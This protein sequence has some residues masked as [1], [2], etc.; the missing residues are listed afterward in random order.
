[1]S[2]RE[3]KTLVHNKKKS[4]FRGKTGGYGPSRDALHRLP[5]QRT[6]IFRLGA[7]RCRLNGHLKRIGEK[8]S[9]RCPCGEAD[10][11]PEHYLQS[12]S[13]YHQIKQQIWP[14]CV[15]L[16]TKLWQ[17][18]EDLFLTSKCAAFNATITSNAEVL[19][20]IHQS[21]TTLGAGRNT[22]HSAGSPFLP[23]EPQLTVS[24]PQLTLSV[25]VPQLTVSVP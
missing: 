21:T 18:A 24:V 12:C 9:A 3:V 17:S 5:H 16:K 7:G 19:V 20:A 8:T 2:C 22:L 23:D 15:S 10:Q 25:S 13:L 4:V 6:T 1:M 11:T 14:V